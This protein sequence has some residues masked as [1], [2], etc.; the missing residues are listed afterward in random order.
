V[1]IYTS[2]LKPGAPPV[3]LREGFSLAAAIFG[4]LWL[5]WHRAWIAAALL[6][7]T[8]VIVAKLGDLTHSPALPLG[9]MALQGMFGRDLV[10]WN[11]ARIGYQPGPVVLAANDDAA[12]TRLVTERADLFP[13]LAE[14]LA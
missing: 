6:F 9:L 12:L 8:F 13:N 1:K 14:T 5:L 2:H 7:A 11:L 4:F 3:V 10:R